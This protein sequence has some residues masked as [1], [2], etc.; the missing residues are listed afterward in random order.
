MNDDC[1]MCPQGSKRPRYNAF[2]IQYLSVKTRSERLGLPSW[3]GNICLPRWTRRL[4]LPR[5]CHNDNSAQPDSHTRHLARNDSSECPLLS[6]PSRESLG[7]DYVEYDLENIVIS[8]GGTKGYA[9]VGALKVSTLGIVHR[10]VG[11]DDA[12]LI[13]I[14]TTMTTTTMISR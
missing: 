3:C 14:I 6:P 4:R 1:T 10:C 12:M 8:G 11:V 7:D 2:G 9:F 5:Q 13:V